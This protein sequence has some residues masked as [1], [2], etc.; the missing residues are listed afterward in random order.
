MASELGSIALFGA[1]GAVGHA[2]GEELSRRGVPYR[3]VGRS[4]A[5][6][7]DFFTGEGVREAAQGIDTIFYLAGAPYTEFFKHPIMVRNAL[8][9]AR[10]ASVK[11][12]VHVAPVYSYGSPRT[13]PVPETQPHAPQT[14][15]GRFRLEQE[16]AVLEQHGDAMRTMVVHLPDFYGPHADLSYANAFMRD[17]LSGKTATWIG[18]L[19][20]QREFIFTGDIAQPLLALAAVDSAYGR[21]WNLGGVSIR[22]RDFIDT[23]FTVLGTKPKYR[24]MPKA[25]LQAVGLFVPMLRE[26]AEM[27]Y[28]FS[29]GFVLDEG[30]LQA[31][32]GPLA[33]TPIRDGVQ[34][35]IAWMRG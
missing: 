15:K 4:K 5:V 2:L 30:A 3:E 16:Q 10:A 24:A 35:T 22:A 6:H 34:R 32:I 21:C 29:D 31:C 28:L 19:D 27:Y 25:M 18:P 14:R 20:A 8:D 7:A 9:A 23:V 11:R 17:A 1:G 33:K 12:F 13:H 26:V